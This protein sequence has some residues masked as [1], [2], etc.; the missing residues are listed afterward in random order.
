MI[1]VLMVAVCSCMYILQSSG[2]LPVSV[3]TSVFDG[4][5]F[6]VITERDLAAGTLKVRIRRHV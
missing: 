5:A 3:A 4:R 2:S 1:D 6:A